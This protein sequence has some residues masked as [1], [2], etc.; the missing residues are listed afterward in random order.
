MYLT[1]VI[2]SNG[3]VLSTYEDGFPADEFSGKLPILHKI[4]QYYDTKN[5]KDL[6]KKHQLFG[7]KWYIISDPISKESIEVDM[8]YINSFLTYIDI[9]SGSEIEDVPVTDI[10]NKVSELNKIDVNRVSI[11]D[12]PY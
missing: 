10:I 5:K 12:L 7:I 9:Y 11:D 6:Q 1:T 8:K 3:V 4:K 2:Y